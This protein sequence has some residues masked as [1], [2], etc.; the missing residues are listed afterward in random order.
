MGESQKSWD[1]SGFLGVFVLKIMFG[2][3]I[4]FSSKDMWWKNIAIPYMYGVFTY[5][6]YTIHGWYG[7]VL[8]LRAF[9][10]ISRSIGDLEN[11]E[12]FELGPRCG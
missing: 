12:T 8:R 11:Y 7:I 3:Q 1:I 9:H 6:Y 10:I 5:I 2:V 4:Q